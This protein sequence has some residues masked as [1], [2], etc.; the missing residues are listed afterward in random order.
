MWGSVGWSAY[1]GRC[2]NVGATKMRP[3]L[4]VQVVLPDFDQPVAVAVLILGLDRQDV[5]DRVAGTGLQPVGQEDPD[6]GRPR[7]VLGLDGMDQE[8][9]AIPL[10]LGLDFRTWTG[11]VDGKNGADQR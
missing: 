6:P 1:Q 8:A 4:V 2:E 7:L 11:V 9:V 3:V 10:R 5:D